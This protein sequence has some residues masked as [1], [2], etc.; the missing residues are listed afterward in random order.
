[1]LIDLDRN[2]CKIRH[3]CHLPYQSGVMYNVSEMHWT[4]EMLDWR[5]LAYV[6]VFCIAEETDD[7]HA[8]KVPD[9]LRQDIFIKELLK[10]TST[11]Q[12]C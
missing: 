8:M 4:C 7:Y 5:Q 9:T 1:M 6:V 2:R 11:N 3:P 12:Y 10:G